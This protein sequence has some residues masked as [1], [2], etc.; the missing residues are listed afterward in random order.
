MLEGGPIEQVKT[1][2]GRRR[3]VEAAAL[4]PEQEEKPDTFGAKISFLSGRKYWYQTLFC[5]VS[6]QMHLPYKVTP[7]VFD[8]GSFD[9]ETRQHMYRTI[10]WIK[11]VGIEEIEARLDRQ[12]PVT[13]FPSLRARRLEYP[14]LKK[15]TDIHVGQTGWG[16]VFDSD[17]LFYKAPDEISRWFR[18]PEA[19]YMQDIHDAYGY[20]SGLLMEL[21]GEP[22]LPLVNAGLYGLHREKIDWNR[23]EHWC[24][25][26]ILK[27]GKNYLQEQGLTALELTKQQATPLSAERYRLM[28]DLNE[29]SSPTATLH[30]FVANSK[31]SYFQSG[32]KRVYASVTE[33]SSATQN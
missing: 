32:W 28:P 8:D 17:M 6:L 26:Q 18:A 5:F 9:D 4:L 15:F 14:H 25:Q 16:L 22:I 3:M 7:I 13:E 1:E 33:T 27:E 12:L 10:P 21:L 24:S 2:R 31:R 23:F 11:F 19:I 20:S 30:H 29:G